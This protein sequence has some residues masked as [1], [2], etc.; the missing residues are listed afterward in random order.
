MANLRAKVSK[1]TDDYINLKIKREDLESFC[2]SVGL[3]RKE[4]IKTLDSSEKDHREGRIKERN[5]L[6]ELIKGKK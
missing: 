2:S 1:N 5:S 3:F 4:F 6:Y